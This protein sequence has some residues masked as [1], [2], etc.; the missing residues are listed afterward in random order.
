M[1]EFYIGLMSGTSLDGIDAL[2]VS[3]PPTDESGS[4]QVLAHSFKPFDPELKSALLALN[5]PL[6]QE[7]HLAALAGNRVASSYA[8][9]VRELDRKSVV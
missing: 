2:L 6:D 8:E 1:S 9:R 4:M 7:L 5:G 3:F